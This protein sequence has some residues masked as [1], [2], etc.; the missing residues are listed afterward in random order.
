MRILNKIVSESKLQKWMFILMYFQSLSIF[1]KESLILK[2]SHIISKISLFRWRLFLH[3][4]FG[5]VFAKIRN[6]EDKKSCWIMGDSENSRTILYNAGYLSGWGFSIFNGGF[7]MYIV[8]FFIKHTLN[9]SLDEF[10]KDHHLTASVPITAEN[11][12]LHQENSSISW[13][14]TTKRKVVWW[15]TCLMSITLKYYL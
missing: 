1:N 3:T 2:M 4:K 14:W 6:N 5:G 8:Y 13:T 7:W 9:S 12:P 15:N 11:S 10:F